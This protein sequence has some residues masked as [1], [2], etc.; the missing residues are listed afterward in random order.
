MAI[1]ASRV[2]SEREVSTR[3]V[4]LEHEQRPGQ[5]Q[6]IDEGAEQTDRDEQAVALAKRRANLARAVDVGVP[7]PTG[8][9]VSRH[10]LL[11]AQAAPTSP[12]SPRRCTRPGPL[13]PTAR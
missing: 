12:R 6:Q 2:A 10:R 7:T 8:P 9:L 1:S 4:D 3:S 11:D 5:H 13:L